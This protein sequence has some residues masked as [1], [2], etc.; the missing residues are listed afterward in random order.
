MIDRRNSQSSKRFGQHT[1][2]SLVSLYL[3][4]VRWPFGIHDSCRAL[5]SETTFPV[6]NDLMVELALEGAAFRA[7]IP[8]DSPKQMKSKKP[9]YFE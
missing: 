5:D 7:T 6:S 8:T 9:I 1:N 3:L 4:N 2:P